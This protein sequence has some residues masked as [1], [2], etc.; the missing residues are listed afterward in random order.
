MTLAEIRTAGMPRLPRIRRGAWAPVCALLLLCLAPP[1]AAQDKPKSKPYALIFGTVFEAD[2]RLAYGIPVK[3]RRAD[4]K[5]AFMEA[6][7]D[8]AGEFAFRV[9]PGPAEYVVWADIKPD[10]KK[11]RKPEGQAPAAAAPGSAAVSTEKGQ[12]PEVRVKVESEERI[13]IGLH[14][15]E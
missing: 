5:K 1:A 14:L 3:I 12:R 13:D 9:P 10:K 2:G 8:H 4:Q 15:T 7:S 11:K 6:M